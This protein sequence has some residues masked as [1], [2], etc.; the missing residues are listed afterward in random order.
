[1][2]LR[3]PTVILAWLGDRVEGSALPNQPTVLEI[4]IHGAP[5]YHGWLVVQRDAAP[6]GCV[7]DPMLAESRYIFLECGAPVMIG[8]AR[9]HRDWQKALVDGSLRADGDPELVERLP[10]WFAGQMP[11]AG[12]PARPAL[13]RPRSPARG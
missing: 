7:E 11:P 9:G 13:A 1:M 8:L 5:E 10:D 12:S 3:D 6:Y 4:T 2:A